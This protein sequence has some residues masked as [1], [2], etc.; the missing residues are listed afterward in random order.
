MEQKLYMYISR[1]MNCYHNY[2]RTV[3]QI[4]VSRLADK[5]RELLIKQTQHFFNE[6]QNLFKVIYQIMDT[7]RSLQNTKEGIRV[8]VNW[9]M[10]NSL[11]FKPHAT[12]LSIP[13]KFVFL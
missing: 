13:H 12:V 11:P 4:I 2:Q 10:Y 9:F 1:S 6:N 3:K 8:Q 5:G 7:N